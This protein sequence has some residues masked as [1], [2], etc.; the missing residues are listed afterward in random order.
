M[1]SDDRLQRPSGP[2]RQAGC[3]AG[4]RSVGVQGPCHSHSAGGPAAS[5]HASAAP[6]R[7]AVEVAGLVLAHL[8]GVCPGAGGQGLGGQQQGSGLEGAALVGAPL[9]GGR[10]SQHRGCASGRGWGGRCEGGR[11]GRCGRLERFQPSGA[12]MA[13]ALGC[14]EQRLRVVG[15]GMHGSPGLGSRS[16]PAV[17]GRRLAQSATD[18]SRHGH[19]PSIHGTPSS[20]PPAGLMACNLAGFVVGPDGL[21][22]FVHELASAPGTCAVGL[23]AFHSAAQLMFVWRRPLGPV[24]GGQQA[25]NPVH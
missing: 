19:H 15:G 12:A 1:E 11:A 20:P 18:P 17:E 7:F 5:R 8:P 16:Q 4:R 14:G 2:I 25:S 9:R 6:R 24:G 3:S 22:E 10:G 13:L 23:L 21:L